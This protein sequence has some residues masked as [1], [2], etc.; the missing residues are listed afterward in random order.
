MIKI[1]GEHFRC[2][3]NKYHK[4][5]KIKYFSKAYF[6]RGLYLE[7]FIYGRK[8]AFQNQLGEPYSWK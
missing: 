8:F 7:G 1:S 6:L 2:S 4:I 3:S 5:P